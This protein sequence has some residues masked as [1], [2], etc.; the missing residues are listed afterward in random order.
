MTASGWMCSWC[1][2]VNEGELDACWRCNRDRPMR[3]PET[4][5]TQTA[6]AVVEHAEETDAHRLREAFLALRDLGYWARERQPRGIRAIPEDVLKLGRS[7]VLWD[8]E[9]SGSFD[10]GGNLRRA[11][12]LHH[13]SKDA[14]EI[15][16]FLRVRGFDVAITEGPKGEDEVIVH[17]A[18]ETV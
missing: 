8:E 3:M 5:M 10:P 11:L 17:P 13:L 7:W 16:R 4:T 18:R 14:A 9:A 1:G 2:A 15:A 12:H 6:A